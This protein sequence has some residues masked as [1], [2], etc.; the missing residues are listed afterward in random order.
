MDPHLNVSTVNRSPKRH[1]RLS[2]R[3]VTRETQSHEARGL[4][5]DG[6]CYVLVANA[7]CHTPGTQWRHRQCWLTGDAGDY[8][9]HLVAGTLTNLGNVIRDMGDSVAARV[10]H[11][12]AL[13]IQRESGD[14]YSFATTLNNLSLTS[15]DLGL[16]GRAKMEAHRERCIAAGMNGHLPKPVEPS[17]LYQTALDWMS[18]NK[19]S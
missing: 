1:R 19:S 10:V 12:E 7:Y 4:I 6:F 13:A 17:V 9:G 5:A 11:E 18:S 3:S 8:E 14:R 16:P 2:K 15:R